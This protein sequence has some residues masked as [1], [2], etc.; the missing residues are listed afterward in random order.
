MDLSRVQRGERI[1]IIGG[2]L[3]AIGL[4]LTW[5]HL[6][7]NGAAGGKTGPADL[8]GWEAH[9]TMR[10]FLLAAAVAPLIL[11]YIIARDHALSWPRG[12]LT[13]V[14]AIAAFGLV[15]Y[16]G[17][18]DKPG[19]SNSLIGLKWGWIVAILGPIM[20]LLGSVIRQNE[21][22]I[23]RKPPGTL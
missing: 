9:P 12:Q 8:T 17:I 1:A 16:S 3:L 13:S 21:T 5:Y 14:V 6:D 10:W 7:K 18:I 2:I 22:E 11:A 15:G 19:D 4:F 20:M 23:K